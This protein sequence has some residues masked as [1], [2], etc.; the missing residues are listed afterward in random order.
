[1]NISQFT[2]NSGYITGYT[3]TDTLNSVTGRGNTTSNSVRFGTHV[4]LSPTAS[5]FRFYDG[6][7]FTGHGSYKTIAAYDTT[8]YPMAIKQNNIMLIGCHPEAEKWWYDSYS[9]LK[10]SYTN[11]QPKL[12]EVVNQLMER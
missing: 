2:N 11:H 10:G 5:A 12:L 7:T 6:P 9:Y 3:E 1:M 8:G 4:D